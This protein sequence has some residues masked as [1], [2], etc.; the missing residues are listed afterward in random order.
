MLFNIFRAGAFFGNEFD[1]GAEEV[2]EE[3]PFIAA[4]GIEK[5]DGPWII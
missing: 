2:I 1:E 3:P 5:G 4:G